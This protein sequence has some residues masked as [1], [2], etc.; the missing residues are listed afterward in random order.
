[1]YSHVLYSYFSHT[2]D[3][4]YMLNKELVGLG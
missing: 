2:A 1:V 3:S 4:H